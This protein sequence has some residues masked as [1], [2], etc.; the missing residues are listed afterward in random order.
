MLFR[1]GIT[2]FFSCLFLDKIVGSVTV[3]CLLELFV[4]DKIFGIFLT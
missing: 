2:K 4:S 3:K 1:I